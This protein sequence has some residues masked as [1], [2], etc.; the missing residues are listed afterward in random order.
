MLLVVIDYLIFESDIKSLNFSCGSNRTLFLCEDILEME[1]AAQKFEK[2]C[3]ILD[4]IQGQ[5]YNAEELYSYPLLN[6]LKRADADGYS[7][8]CKIEVQLNS[9]FT[10][11]AAAICR[12]GENECVSNSQ[13][14]LSCI[15]ENHK[16]EP[17]DPSLSCEA[18][19]LCSVVDYTETFSTTSHVRSD[20]EL[21]LSIFVA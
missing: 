13:P 6:L 16:P 17:S 12:L 19:T 18:S 4:E 9:E 8:Y 14:T 2:E 20:F 21:N 3:G 7:P 11:A 15:T 1:S 5:A 10:A